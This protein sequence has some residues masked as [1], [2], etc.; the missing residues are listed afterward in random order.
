MTL[1][2][3]RR[4]SFYIPF[5]RLPL[6]LSSLAKY[7]SNTTVQSLIMVVP[8]KEKR[9]FQAAFVEKDVQVLMGG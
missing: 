5:L 7:T 8:D 1:T 4:F 2:N 9:A 3:T 6:L